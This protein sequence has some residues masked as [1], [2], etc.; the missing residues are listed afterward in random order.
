[1]VMSAESSPLEVFKEWLPGEMRY[2]AQKHP[3]VS[4]VA[5]CSRSADDPQSVN[6]RLSYKWYEHQLLRRGGNRHALS[7][8]MTAQTPL[9]KFAAGIFTAAAVARWIANGSEPK[10]EAYLEQADRV[11]E[12]VCNSPITGT[13]FQTFDAIAELEKPYEKTIFQ[14]GVTGLM[15]RIVVISEAEDVTRSEQTSVLAFDALCYGRRAVQ[16]YA[17]YAST[18]LKPEQYYLAPS[19]LAS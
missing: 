6:A 12:L 4:V 14:K 11:A 1:M 17:A 10:A 2:I 9:A 19:N 3:Y 5:D 7:Y 13:D 16:C 15:R 18:E 8:Q